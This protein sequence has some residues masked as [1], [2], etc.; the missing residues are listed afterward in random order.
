MKYRSK[1]K[2]K[3]PEIIT[4]S[5]AIFYR[6]TKG[7]W[8]VLKDQYLGREEI[9]D[10][11]KSEQRINS[12]RKRLKL[13]AHPIRFTVCGCNDPGCAGW[14]RIDLTVKE[15][16]KSEVKEILREGKKK[17]PKKKAPNQSLKGSALWPVLVHNTLGAPP[18]F[19]LGR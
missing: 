18:N 1:L 9:I 8:E 2:K 4:E 10:A 14:H 3:K 11:I 5:K 7:A 12:L 13:K 17:Y 15:P 16:S 6:N 19:M